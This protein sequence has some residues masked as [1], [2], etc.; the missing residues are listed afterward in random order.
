MGILGWRDD[1]GRRIE[2]DGLRSGEYAWKVHQLFRFEE[3]LIRP[4][5]RLKSGL[6]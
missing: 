4:L 5:F 3:W 2:D 1:S 6:G